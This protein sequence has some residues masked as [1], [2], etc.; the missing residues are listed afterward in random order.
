VT[1]GAQIP[2]QPPTFDAYA[3]PVIPPDTVFPTGLYANW[4]V[5][6]DVPLGYRRGI[7]ENQCL[8]IAIENAPEA[9]TVRLHFEV[10]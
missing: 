10:P 4:N 9:G 8:V 1:N 7:D 5:V 6:G 3:G 2:D